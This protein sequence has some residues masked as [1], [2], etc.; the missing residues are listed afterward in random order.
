MSNT[1]VEYTHQPLRCDYCGEPLIMTMSV[2]QCPDC[3]SRW[4]EE[5]CEP[6]SHAYAMRILD[7]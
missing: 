6:G 7:A 2:I 1:L 3:R 5:H 4:L